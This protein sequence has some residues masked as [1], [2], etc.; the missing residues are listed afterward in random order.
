VQSVTAAEQ[1]N[2]LFIL[3][4]LFF[5]FFSFIPGSYLYMVVV[6][7]T[8]VVA[9]VPAFIVVVAGVVELP[10]VLGSFLSEAFSLSLSFSEVISSSLL[11]QP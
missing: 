9:A 7:I 11:P 8:I 2:T 6:V 10:W 5:F 3:L 4:L 1:P